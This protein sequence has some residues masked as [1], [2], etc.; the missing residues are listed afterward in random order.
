MAGTTRKAQTNGTDA[1][2]QTAPSPSAGTALLEAIAQA[3]ASARKAQ[4]AAQ[5]LTPKK[6]QAGPPKI[7]TFFDT[8]KIIETAQTLATAHADAMAKGETLQALTPNWIDLTEALGHSDDDPWIGPKLRTRLTQLCIAGKINNS[9]RP[10]APGA[11]PL[12]LAQRAAQAEAEQLDALLA[13]AQA[14]G[15]ELPTTNEQE[16]ETAQA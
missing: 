10:T 3:Q 11:K 15:I 12:Y 9:Y 5:A 7:R 14:L 2:S 13:Q 1:A 6:R 16:T 8:A 4:E